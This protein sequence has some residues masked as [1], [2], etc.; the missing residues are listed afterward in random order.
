MQYFTGCGE[1]LAKLDT[2]RGERWVDSMTVQGRAAITR[3]VERLS[4]MDKKIVNVYDKRRFHMKT[5]PM[6]TD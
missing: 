1:R 3:P 4:R 2:G 5:H 6:E